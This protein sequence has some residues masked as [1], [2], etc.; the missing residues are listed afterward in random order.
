MQLILAR[1]EGSNRRHTQ[2]IPSVHEKLLTLQKS[3][4][5]LKKKIRTLIA[6]KF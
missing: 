4:R 5:I 6:D 3:V 2:K 1:I